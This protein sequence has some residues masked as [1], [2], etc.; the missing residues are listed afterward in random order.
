[1]SQS[2]WKYK[3]PIADEFSH[4][5]PVAAQVIHVESQGG[6]PWLWALVTPGNVAVERTFYLYGTGHTIP[7]GR[8]HLGSFHLHG[9]AFV[10]HVFEDAAARLAGQ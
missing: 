7:P 10:G 1:M 5:M 9:G 6:E 8:V 2:V 3:I 4:Q